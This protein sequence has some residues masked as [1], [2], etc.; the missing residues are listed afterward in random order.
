MKRF[1]LISNVVV[2]G[3]YLLFSGQVLAQDPTID[4][5][6]TLEKK[7]KVSRTEYDFSYYV[8]IINTGDAIK[9]VTASVSSTSV[10]TVVIDGSVNFN[11]VP[12]GE[13]S[14]SIDTFTIRQNR[15]HAFDPDS[16]VWDIQYELANNDGLPPDP[17]EEGLLTIEGI[18]SD[19]DGVRDDVQIS[20]AKHYPDN[21]KAKQALMQLAKGLQEGFISFD[22]NNTQGLNNAVLKIVSAAKCISFESTTPDVDIAYVE[23]LMMNTNARGNAFLEV[24]FAASGKF[25]T[26]DIE[27]NEI[28]CER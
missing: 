21:A 22:Q 10:N 7:H 15:R 1:S 24:S 13:S 16:L 19:S 6:Y 5:Q 28:H 20:I 25:F 12:T 18:D 4:Q 26:S 8:K 9:N 3:I 2:F 17:G 14:Q 11:D 23:S 27:Q